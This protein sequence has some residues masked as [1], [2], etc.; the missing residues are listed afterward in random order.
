MKCANCNTEFNSNFCPN[1][2]APATEAPVPIQSASA[3]QPQKKKNS[4]MKIIA[5][6]AVIVFL[7]SI[8]FIIHYVWFSYVPDVTFNSVVDCENIVAEALNKSF[9]LEA[10]TDFERYELSEQTLQTLGPNYVDEK[11]HYKKESNAE[12]NITKH[13]FFDI[14][15]KK[16]K[17]YTVMYSCSA[18]ADISNI[19]DSVESFWSM[20]SE[21]TKFVL[22]DVKNNYYNSSELNSPDSLEKPFFADS[23]FNIPLNGSES[24][25]VVVWVEFSITTENEKSISISYNFYN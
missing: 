22:E 1:C 15:G 13:Q 25:Y 17:N 8:G 20:N 10:H 23:H 21:Y 24:K 4:S 12:N 3:A 2:G 11:E 6:V 16:L 14:D 9:V 19:V 7:F 18:D 5:I